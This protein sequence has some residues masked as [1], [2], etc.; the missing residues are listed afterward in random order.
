MMFCCLLCSCCAL[1]CVVGIYC[2]W[3]VFCN[4]VVAVSKITAVG[5]FYIAWLGVALKLY[6]RF[7]LRWWVFNKIELRIHN[8][9]S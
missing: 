1:G 2:V 9:I 4:G 7:S 8:A 3:I 5:V 6:I